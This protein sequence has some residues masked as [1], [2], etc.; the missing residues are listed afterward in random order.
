M[1]VIMAL[2]TTFMAGPYLNLVDLYERR[3]SRR[4]EPVAIGS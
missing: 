2:V 1:M 4:A 3:R